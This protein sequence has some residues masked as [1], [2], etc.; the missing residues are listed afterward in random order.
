MITI[1]DIEII[2]TYTVTYRKYVIKV[3]YNVLGEY[4]SFDIFDPGLLF[5]TKAQEQF[6]SE[7]EILKEIKRHVDNAIT[8]NYFK[9]SKN[10]TA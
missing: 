7:Q 6:N 1:T 2:K 8:R 5:I 4:S 3:K 10:S 9:Q